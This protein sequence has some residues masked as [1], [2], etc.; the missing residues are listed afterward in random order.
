MLASSNV[1]HMLL[2]TMAKFDGRPR[3]QCTLKCIFGV[4][5][6]RT[7]LCHEAMQLC[8]LRLR[9]PPALHEGWRA[10]GR[11]HRAESWPRGAVGSMHT[12]LC[13]ETMQLWQL[14]LGL[15]PSLHEG[16]RAVGRIHGAECWPREVSLACALDEQDE[17]NLPGA[18]RPN[19]IRKSSLYDDGLSTT[20]CDVRIAYESQSGQAGDCTSSGNS[21]AA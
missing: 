3:A 19:D 1:S 21:Q 6:M 10:V 11:V 20:P 4:D 17:R 14:R 5:S 16:W 9:L 7:E 18:W 12:T 15:P 13:H 2:A 8:Q